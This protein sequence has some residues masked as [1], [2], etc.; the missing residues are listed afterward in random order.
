MLI[1]QYCIIAPQKAVVA[2]ISRTRKS[3]WTFLSQL[4]FAMVTTTLAVVATPLLLRYLGEERFGAFRVMVDWV[5]YIALLDLGLSGGLI[6]CL[7]RAIARADRTA[8]HSI[9]SASL[10]MF[11]R[12]SVGMLIAGLV[13]A[14]FAPRLVASQTLTSYEIRTATLI[15]VIPSLAVPL[16]VFRSLLECQQRGYILNC[17]LIVQSVGTVGLSL[18]CAAAGWGLVGQAVG[19]VL[20]QLPLVAF[21]FLTGVR[22]YPGIWR[23]CPDRQAVQQFRS[24]NWPTFWFTLSGRIAFFSDNILIGFLIGPAAVAPFYLTQRFAGLIQVQ[25]QAVG[26]S[27]WAGLVELHTSN[28][29]AFK[30]RLVELTE[31]VSGLGLVC[32]G[33]IVAYNPHLLR[34]WVGNAGFAGDAVSTLACMNVWLSAI[35]SLWGWPITGVGEIRRLLP[36]VVLSTVIN[37]MASLLC[38]FKLGLIG[39]L[40]GTMIAFAAISSW[41]IPRVLQNV[42]GIDPKRLWFAALSP[43]AWALPNGLLWWWLARNHRPNNWA[44]LGVEIMA[45]ATSFLVL[46]WIVQLSPAQRAVWHHRFRLAFQL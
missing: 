4:L 33:P 37:V 39:P 24:L 9:I 8:V 28:A 15:M 25:L 13:L 43:F 23:I 32:I 35:C 30:Q 2:G 26:N 22:N 14:A 42:F 10:R 29:E 27:T 6:G 18:A 45:A 5:G 3:A 20:G 41:A 21:L 17:L 31:M 46:W 11:C 34:L 36:Y 44:M 38:T 16:A 1:L 12:L 7:G 40:L 19:T